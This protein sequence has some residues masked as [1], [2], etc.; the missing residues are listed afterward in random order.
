MNRSTLN[1]IVDSLMFTTCG[2]TIFIGILLGFVIPTGN[3]PP[4]Q[5]YLWELHRHDWGDIHL[6]LALA[7]LGLLII[8][9]FLHWSWI[10]GCAGKYFGKPTYLWAFAL[11]PVALVLLIW[12][13]YPRGSKH[14][15]RGK[16]FEVGVATTDTSAYE[17]L[18]SSAHSAGRQH[19]GRGKYGRD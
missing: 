2:A 6:Y 13:T 10:K 17:P 19:E 3:A 16:G 5:K 18:E 7:F 15:E 9:L 4:Q 14:A 8:H 11:A 1:F 12:L